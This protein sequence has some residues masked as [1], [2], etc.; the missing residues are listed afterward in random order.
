LTKGTLCDSKKSTRNIWGQALWTLG[1]IG[2][3][4]K[5]YIC[6]SLGY[7]GSG[8]WGESLFCYHCMVECNPEKQEWGGRTKGCI[9]PYSYLVRVLL[10]WSW[11][12]TNWLLGIAECLQGGHGNCCM[13]DTAWG[14]RWG[15]RLC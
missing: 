6:F 7:P 8:A 1:K 3:D 12:I 15:W 10:H 14:R 2:N 4:V 13:S 11:L 5:L 9:C